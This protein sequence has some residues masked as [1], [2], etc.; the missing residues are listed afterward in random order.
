MRPVDYQIHDL[1]EL[2]GIST[3]TLRYY[4]S[5]GLLKP[6]RVDA[7]GYRM[8]GGAE[9]DRLQSI[10]FYRELGMPLEQIKEIL[11]SATYDQHV[12]L[13][14]H[15]DQLRE[16]KDRLE[17]LIQT[18]EKS[19]AAMKGEITMSDKEKFEGLKR[20][21]VQENEE[22]Y[23]EEVRMKY[24][25]QTVNDS[26]SQLMGLSPEK[27]ARV[28][29]LSERINTLLAQAVLTGNPADPAAQEACA[30]HREW[31]GFFWKSYSKEAHKG[32]AQMYVED[33]RF[34]EYYDAIGEG[35]AE[36]FRDALLIFC[37]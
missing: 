33:E 18:V 12:A 9:V 21:L 32:L 15:L 2:A 11:A 16:K 14:G 27:F 22:K 30:L 8:Y 17:Q 13:H 4:D 25:D 7:N 24:G 28:T 26:N 20:K 19:I 31:L 5:I 37:G 1:A 23:G 10:L 35:C 3:R 36:Y 29:E 34:R 6:V